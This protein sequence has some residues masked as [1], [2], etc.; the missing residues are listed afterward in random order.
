MEINFNGITEIVAVI[1]VDDSNT[2]C[3]FVRA[4]GK[5]MVTSGDYA[6]APEWGYA[7]VTVSLDEED[8][9]LLREVI[10]TPEEAEKKGFIL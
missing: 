9:D 8:M 7:G 10:M 2:G 6:T 3:L 4:D 5:L 1:D